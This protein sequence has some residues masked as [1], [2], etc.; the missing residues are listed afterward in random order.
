MILLINQCNY[1]PSYIIE[2]DLLLLLLFTF[3]IGLVKYKL[4]RYF[5][6]G[7]FLLR[8]LL[9]TS[10]STY[11]KVPQYPLEEYYSN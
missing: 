2:M 3:L 5:F 8:V 11:H 1:F 6:Y 4:L 7:R 9:C 10:C